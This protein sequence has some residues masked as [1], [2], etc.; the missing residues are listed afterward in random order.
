M[1]Q[2]QPV[3]IFVAGQPGSGKTVLA[4]LLYAALNQRL[5][6]SQDVPGC[7]SADQSKNELGPPRL[8]AAYAA[9][10][11]GACRLE[12]WRCRATITRQT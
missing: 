12:R 2:D 7:Q 8:S 10:A 6:A 9:P 3:V 1:S 11:S 5:P 4:N